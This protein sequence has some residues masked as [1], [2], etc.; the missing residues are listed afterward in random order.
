[1]KTEIDLN[2]NKVKKIEPPKLE[3]VKK[4]KFRDEITIGVLDDLGLSIG[5]LTE[6]E[7]LKKMKPRFLLD[8]INAMMIEGKPITL[9]TG[10]AELEEIVKDMS[11][12]L[13]VSQRKELAKEKLKSNRSPA[14]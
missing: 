5:E 6:L 4:R 11:S 3:V 10:Q 8:F 13:E 2:M 1:M 7:D 9:D 14:V 12:F